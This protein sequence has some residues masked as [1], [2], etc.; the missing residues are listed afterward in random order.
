MRTTANLG[1][2]VWDSNSDTFDHTVLAANWDKIDADYTRTRPTNSA[3]VRTTL[4]TSGNFEGRLAYLTASDGGFAAGT[5]VKFNGGAWKSV[6]N[7]EVLGAIPTTGN[8]A[9]RMVLLS[10]TSGTFAAWALI[11]YD[12]AAWTL[13]NYSYELLSTLP[14]TNNFAGRLVVL[15]AADS[16]FSAWDL[17]RFNGSTWT[18][19]GPQPTPPGTELGYVTVNADTTTANSIDPGDT[20]VTFTAAT[21]EQTKYYL[22]INLPM[23]SHTVSSEL[24]S[25]RLQE[26]GTNVGNPVATHSDPTPGKFK[27]FSS[28]K[29]P[30]TP[31]AG[32]HTYSVT[33][34]TASGTATINATGY[35]PAVL[36][37]F[38]G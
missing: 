11:K 9:G 34:W 6:S 17:V 35:A 7:V 24:V 25:L 13:A 15:S 8:Y 12:G 2:T 29:I 10:S 20:L 31:S 27:G 16:G 36:R 1:L 21:F 32:S 5:L 18:R 23:L 4:P 26:T 30:F 33:W 3:E 37:I 38:K 28:V 19:I 22:E 14:T